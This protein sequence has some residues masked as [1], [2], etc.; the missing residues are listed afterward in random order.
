MRCPKC[1]STAIYVLKTIEKEEF[2]HRRRECRKCHY[3]FSTKEMPYDGW[4]YHKLY[5]KLLNKVRKIL[6]EESHK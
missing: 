5:N 4:N 3:R 2:I 1:N 6:E